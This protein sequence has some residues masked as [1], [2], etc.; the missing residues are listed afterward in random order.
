M[1][2]YGYSPPP[3]S[4][5]EKKRREE[6]IKI[7][8]QREKVFKEMLLELYNL[9]N[10]SPSTLAVEKE[11]CGRP[12]YVKNYSIT[13]YC[14]KCGGGVQQFIENKL[15]KII[16]SGNQIYPAYSNINC[17]T[18][19]SDTVKSSKFKIKQSVG[20]LI[21][22]EENGDGYIQMSG[23]RYYF[24][25]YAKETYHYRKEQCEKD[26]IFFLENII[27][28]SVGR[29]DEEKCDEIFSM[30]W[31]YN[32]YYYENPLRN[33]GKEKVIKYYRCVKCHFE[34]HLYKPND[35]YYLQIFN[36]KKKEEKDKSGNNE[37]KKEKEN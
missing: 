21:K 26:P 4:E 33:F 15:V 18:Y 22:E 24:T 31:G 17:L 30:N 34:Y 9:K 32:Y 37:D 29:E 27:R 19:E 28:N 14:P 2:I 1:G 7:N 11:K 6:N 23:N 8:A 20:V 3:L 12:T 25:S 35:L 36:L 13:F 16:N 10:N 5:E